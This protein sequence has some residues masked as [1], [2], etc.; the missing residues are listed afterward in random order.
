MYSGHR[1]PAHTEHELTV[2]SSDNT[3]E[4]VPIS[5]FSKVVKNLSKAASP[6]GAHWC[7]MKDCDF[8]VCIWYGV[9]LAA[10]RESQLWENCKRERQD[11]LLGLQKSCQ[12]P[13]LST[14]CPSDIHLASWKV[15]T[16]KTWGLKRTFQLLRDTSQQDG[17]FEKK[18]KGTWNSRNG[19]DF[20][21]E[22]HVKESDTA[23]GKP[24][25]DECGIVLVWKEEPDTYRVCWFW[26]AFVCSSRKIYLTYHDKHVLKLSIYPQ[27]QCAVGVCVSERTK[28][29]VP[30]REKLCECVW[31]DVCTRLCSSRNHQQTRSFSELSSC[32]VT[33]KER[34]NK[35]WSPFILSHR[36]VGPRQ[37]KKKNFHSTS[38]FASSLLISQKKADF[39]TAPQEFDENER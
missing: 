9:F 35:V 5:H 19:K 14:L 28:A 16:A 38:F 32:S 13:F 15:K 3:R 17:V 25:G 34:F 22:R 24:S 37:K 8:S 29:D 39:I 26:L 12:K 2:S 31:H 11:E 36:S 23:F 10:T 21:T 6:Q 1:L 7:I 4:N 27:S 18:R 30:D 20:Q 33:L